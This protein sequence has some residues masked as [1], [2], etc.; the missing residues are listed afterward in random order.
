MGVC[1][2]GFILIC[3]YKHD[4]LCGCKCMSL[5]C[6]PCL[7]A[8]VCVAV[9]LSNVPV[10]AGMSVLYVY[11]PGPI[12]VYVYVWEDRVCIRVGFNPLS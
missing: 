12:F 5:H 2:R 11:V 8:P 3:V 7:P 4:W 6:S 1:I 9:S 10:C